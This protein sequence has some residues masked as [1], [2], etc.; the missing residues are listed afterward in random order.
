MPSKV[1]WARLRCCYLVIGVQ[2]AFIKAIEA[3]KQHLNS[4]EDIECYHQTFIDMKEQY[5]RDVEV[6]VKVTKWN[7]N[8]MHL[9]C[10]LI[11]SRT[12]QMEAKLV[13]MQAK[14]H[15]DERF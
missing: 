13:R 4:M 8:H 9:A 11:A 2:E 5:Q 10:I 12:M 15:E 1:S 6:F 14:Y 3:K 7:S